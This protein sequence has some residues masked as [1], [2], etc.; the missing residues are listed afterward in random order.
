MNAG[1]R[2][3][4]LKWFESYLEDR[5]QY[6]EV[7]GMQSRMIK[8]TVG[9]PQGSILGPLLFLVFINDLCLSGINGSVTLFADDTII[10]YFGQSIEEMQPLIISDL[11]ILHKWMASLEPIVYKYRKNKVY[12]I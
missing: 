6:V 1:V 10:F 2:G 12:L 4:E 5:Y 7:N 3:L 8:T 9:V 11:E